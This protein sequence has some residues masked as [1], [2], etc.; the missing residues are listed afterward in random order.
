ML[1]GVISYLINN[2]IDFE[3]DKDIKSLVSFK[4]GGFADIVIYPSRIEQIKGII[5]TLNVNKSKYFVL[6]KGTNTYFSDNGYKGAI[7]STKL[8]KYA[9]VD[10]TNII[11]QCGCNI[12][13]CAAL[14]YEHGL[15][16]MEFTYGLPGGI[17]GCLYM[18][19][20]AF[21]KDMSDIVEITRVLNKDTGEIT[22]I[23]SKD[24]KYS[25]KHSVFMDKKEYFILETVFKLSVGDKP[26]IKNQMDEY[27]EKR[28]NSQP[29]DLPS[30]G[31][32][33]KRPSVGFS[34]KYIDD[35]GLK[36]KRIGD[37]MVSHKH[38][39]F[40]VNMENASSKDINSLIEYIK[41]EVYNKYNVRLEEEIIYVE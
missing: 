18:N 27:L 9:Y 15:S 41:K 11:A 13:D 32:V 26:T 7:I 19:A 10:G 6:G 39:G 16:G 23:S 1:N 4:V 30:A 25:M 33:F 21:N 38:A 2:K 40:I 14:A 8:L 29:L 34:S 12:H 31:S 35:A 22:E 36:G 20:S 5:D 37:A 17:G 3:L 24:H 28:V